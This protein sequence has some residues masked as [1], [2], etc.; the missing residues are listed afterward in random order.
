MALAKESLILLFPMCKKLILKN[1]N[2]HVNFLIYLH[3]AG[4]F[5][6]NY[7]GSVFENILCNI[8]YI[9]VCTKRIC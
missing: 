8:C 3:F 4:F 5:F 6:T 2:T 1:L 7:Y 9:E